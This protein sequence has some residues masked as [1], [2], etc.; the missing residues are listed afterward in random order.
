MFASLIAWGGWEGIKRFWPLIVVGVAMAAG[1]IA[2]VVYGNKRE[3]AGYARAE[4]ELRPIIQ[5]CEVARNDALLANQHADAAIKV[6]QSMYSDLEQEIK[7]RE[8][9]EIAA[10]RAAQEGLAQA[11]RRERLALRRAAELKKVL[12]RSPEARTCET[13]RKALDALREDARRRAAQ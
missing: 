3:A 6:L 5:A 7:D 10:W 12:E 8:A 11:L 2:L 9:R 1:A 13:S 4:G